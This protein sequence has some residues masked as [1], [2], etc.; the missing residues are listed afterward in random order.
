MVKADKIIDNINLFDR[1]V[2]S[3]NGEDGIIEMIFRKIGTTDKFCVEFGVND[4]HECNTRYLIEK[5]GWNYLH[6]D[7][8]SYKKTYTD[9][10]KEFIT[11][12]NINKLFKKYKVPKEF[13]LLSIDIDFND[14]WVWKALKGYKPRVIIMEY[15]A[16][17]PPNESKTVPYSANR[18]WDGT[19]YYGASILALEKLGKIKGYSLIGCDKKGINA[20]FVR[21]DLIDGCFAKKTAEESYKPPKWGRN[22]IRR[23]SKKDKY[24]SV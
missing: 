13:D 3:Q 21:N 4:G 20:F 2:F 8:G 12:E 22:V 15:N 1:K 19:M 23:L 5:K 7:G 14:Y 18:V 16:S 11:A 17:I 10:K 24:I 6:M 9:I